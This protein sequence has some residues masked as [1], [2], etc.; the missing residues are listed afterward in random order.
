MKFLKEKAGINRF[1][2]YGIGYID[3]N[4]STFLENYSPEGND[5][6]FI[7]R[8]GELI[9]SAENGRVKNQIPRADVV[10][11]PGYGLN[12]LRN[13]FFRQRILNL[14]GVKYLLHKNENLGSNWQ[15]DYLTF[16]Q[17]IYQLVW[18]EGWW[19]IYEN[20]TA[21]PRIFLAIRYRVET[22][23]QKIIDL[24]FDPEFKLE[25][26]VILEE[27]LPEDFQLTNQALGEVELLEYQPNRLVIKTMAPGN[28]LLFISDNYF[29]GWRVKI[30]GVS[31]KIY[32]ANYTFR[33]VPVAEGE[34][35]VVFSYEPWS[36]KVGKII[37]GI[38]LLL[39][40]GLCLKRRF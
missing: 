2:G 33:A 27:E 36:F 30:D 12:D 14:L 15:P 13:N 35:K 40:L 38:T 29:P 9:S 6:L 3:T 19:Q 20:K 4:F 28:T 25:E 24:I 1:W 7:R 31:Q 16:P 5:P 11:A 37:S 22:E 23:K 21:L 18:Q 34:H 10:L 8:Y 17:E 39:I 32:R 26:E